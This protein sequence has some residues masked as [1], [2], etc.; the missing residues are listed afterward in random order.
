L[1]LAGAAGVVQVSTN[2]F[3][4]GYT[5]GSTTTL[6][7]ITS[8]QVQDAGA[9][10][11]AVGTTWTTG[12]TID[13]A[14]GS[15]VSVTG[16][17]ITGNTYTLMTASAV[18][19]GTTPTLVG[20][21]G[22][23]LRVD[24]ANLLL[25]VAKTTPT[26]SVAPTASAVTVGALLSSSILSGGTATVAGATV[27]GTFAWTTPS[28]VVNA[29]ASYPV[30]FTPT[31]GANYNTAT[32]SVIVTAN[33]A[34]S[35]F[36]D[37]YPGKIMTDFA[38]NGLTWL[39][40]YAFGGNATTQATLPVQDT[41]DPTQLRLNVV[42]RTDDSTLPLTAL[43]GEATT[44]LDLAGGWSASGVSVGDSTD[45]SPVPANTVRKVISVDV[46]SS[47]SRRFL[48]ATITK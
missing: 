29:T 34:G 27:A 16:T 30:T 31:N 38:P 17:P 46:V 25:E 12:G 6:G 4:R 39:A 35:T 44:D 2:G 7:T 20:A 15:K 47:D 32:T 18:I 26:V 3:V 11:V 42:F 24:G 21:A 28:T 22:W 23:A 45:L 8:L 43:G 48:R 1:N 14:T 19:T 40:N 36:E 13:F 10:E 37:A 33:P 5:S 41:S 9:V